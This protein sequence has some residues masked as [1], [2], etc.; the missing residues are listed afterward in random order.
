MAEA[1]SSPAVAVASDASL[2]S[3]PTTS[4]ARAHFA[5]VANRDG[6]WLEEGDDDDD[7]YDTAPSD[8]GGGSDADRSDGGGDDDDEDDVDDE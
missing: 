7:D 1:E 5:F 6:D 3:A 2:E 8:G 4:R